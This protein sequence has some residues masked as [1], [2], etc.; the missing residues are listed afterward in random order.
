[1]TE[2][3]EGPPVPPVPFLLLVTHL[4]TPR[5]QIPPNRN[6]YINLVALRDKPLN[7]PTYELQEARRALPWWKEQAFGTAVLGIPLNCLA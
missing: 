4:N 6:E 3:L 1:L 2:V 7:L 5:I